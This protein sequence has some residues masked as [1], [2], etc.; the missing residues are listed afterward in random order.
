[1]NPGSADRIAASCIAAIAWIGLAIQFVASYQQSAS[2][3]LTLWIVFAYFTITTNLL[4]A[5]VFTGIAADRPA[6]CS[7]WVVG[8]TMLS[9]LL[10]GVIYALLLHGSSEL[11]GASAVAN[12]LL[13]MVTPILVPLFWM[14]FTPKGELTWRHPIL[15]A[16]YPLAYLAYALAR[17]GATGS[18]AYPFMD[19]LRLG[20]GK[21]AL[22]SALIAVAFLFSSFALV[23]IDHRAGSRSAASTG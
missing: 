17:G 19:V 14:S 20:W 13:H 8:G 10:V 12:V 21:T 23:W 16:I 6:F 22:N 5:A 7:G 2:A 4:V 9:I 3:L 15:W 18:Y 1:M 11:S